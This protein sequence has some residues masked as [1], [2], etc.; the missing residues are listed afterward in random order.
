VITRL[1]RKFPTIR[2]VH[3]LDCH[4]SGVMIAALGADM[5]R[6][7]SRLFHDRK[8]N[9]TYV[10]LVEGS[11][12]RRSGIIDCPLR[13]DPDDRPKQIIDHAAGKAAQ[14]RWHLLRYQTGTDRPLSRLQLEPITGRT[15]QLR[16]HCMAMGHPIVGDR[17]YNDSNS[18]RAA[19]MML[20]AEALAFMH[21]VSSAW[22]KLQ[23]ACEF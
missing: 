11:V 14:T 10:A 6:R 22:I 2:V 16:V 4:T 19:R 21:P 1:Q 20:H 23:A 3:R 13:G 12:G 5:Q 18:P 9:K 15:H 17:L 8:M 7:L